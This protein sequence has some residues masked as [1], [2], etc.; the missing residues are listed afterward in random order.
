MMS[1]EILHLSCLDGYCKPLRVRLSGKMVTWA[2]T[3]SY[4]GRNS[5]S[6]PGNLRNRKPNLPR[7]S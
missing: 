4:D 6:L 5:A 2:V 3:V 1:P 7:P